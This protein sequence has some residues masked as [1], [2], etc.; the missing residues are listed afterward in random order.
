MRR[1]VYAIELHMFKMTCNETA[2]PDS[3]WMELYIRG[4]VPIRYGET[5]KGTVNKNEV[6][7]TSAACG[8]CTTFSNSTRPDYWPQER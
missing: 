3:V 4:D 1:F 7:W 8:D 5:D 6:Y 2:Y